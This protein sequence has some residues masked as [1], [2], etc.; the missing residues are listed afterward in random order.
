MRIRAKALFMGLVLVV[1]MVPA[2]SA[3]AACASHNHQTWYNQGTWY[4]S[5][6]QYKPSGT[7]CNDLNDSWVSHTGSYSGW[8]YSG[9][10]W[11]LGSQGWTSHNA[12]TQSPWK[13]LDVGL[14]VGQA[15]KIG[16]AFSG[17]QITARV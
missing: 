13:V 15:Y 9:G 7:T 8:Y 11:H 6:Y 4:S 14:N 17:R 16:N 12:G 10:S 3:M 1:A 2:V 5:S